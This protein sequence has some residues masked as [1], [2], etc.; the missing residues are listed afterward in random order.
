MGAAVYAE[1]YQTD[2][3]GNIKVK[4]PIYETALGK[5]IFDMKR[6]ERDRYGPAPAS[7][8]DILILG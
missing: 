1:Q 2:L 3:C 8:L 7:I 6:Q 5:R 4:E